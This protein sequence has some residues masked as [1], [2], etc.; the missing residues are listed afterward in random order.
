MSYTRLR[1]FHAVAESGSVTGAA[2][3]LHLTQPAVTHQ[4]RALEAHHGV[5]LFH[6]KGRGLVLTPL[7]Q[8]LRDLTRHFFDLE[9]QADE[10]LAAAA[11]LRGGQ[12]R[13]GAD[14]PFHVM[15]PLRHMSLAFPEVRVTVH[16]GNS[17]ELQQ[18]LVDYEVDVAVLAAEPEHDALSGVRIGSHRVCL[19]VGHAHPWASRSTVHLMELEGREMVAR[20]PGSAT[21]RAFRAALAEVGAEPRFVIELGSREAVREA[22]AVGLGMAVISEPEVGTD[23]RVCSVALVGADVL[24][25]EYVVVRSDRRRVPA[26]RAFSAAAC[27]DAP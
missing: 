3:R 23:P 10:L 25:H 8:Q 22:V 14:G 27:G 13:V 26:I 9:R 15:R 11:G 19:A 1:A 16:M 6:R 2:R 24:T 20:E 12:L 4:V 17:A 18:R 7:G 5:E 21:R